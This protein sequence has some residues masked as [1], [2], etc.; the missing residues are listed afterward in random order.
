MNDW[1]KVEVECQLPGLAAFVGA[2]HE[3]MQGSHRSTKRAAE[4][5]LERAPITRETLVEQIE[6][7]GAQFTKLKESSADG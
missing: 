5:I 3:Q 4:K 6:C 1:N 7:I 2:I